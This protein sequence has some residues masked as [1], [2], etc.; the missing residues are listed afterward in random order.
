MKVFLS[1]SGEHSRAL[2]EAYKAWIETLPLRIET[3]ISSKDIAS[4]TRNAQAIHDELD[5]T[6]F[7][8]L[9][10]TK[11]NLGSEWIHFEAGAISKSVE[12]GRIVPLCFG[13]KISELKAPLSQFQ[14]RL[15]NRSGA[16][17]LCQDLNQ[18]S[19]ATVA[20]EAIVTAFDRGWESLER[21][22][23]VILGQPEIHREEREPIEE[24]LELTRGIYAR[25]S[26]LRAG[27]LGGSTVQMDRAVFVPIDED[28]ARE[29]SKTDPYCILRRT[30]SDGRYSSSRSAAA[31]R[32]WEASPEAHPSWIESATGP[33]TTTI[34]VDVNTLNERAWERVRQETGLAGEH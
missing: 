28:L 24:V 22:V 18:A 17:A 31:V 10:L 1:W 21:D 16:L 6:S 2:A 14:A 27:R 8:I 19:E 25:I 13:V 4:G 5:S 7:G 32:F 26:A 3:F 23:A 15:F 11:E 12:R 29:L 20:S 34:Y 33:V 9:F 30:T